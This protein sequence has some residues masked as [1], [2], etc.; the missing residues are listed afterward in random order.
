MHS[1]RYT[2]TFA[3]VICVSCGVLLA[4]VAE[5][6]RPAIEKNEKFDI[7]R[8][9]LKATGILED[10]PQATPETMTQLYEK[11]IREIVINLD[12]NQVPG[13]TPSETDFKK[14]K[15][16][17]PVY[18]R[19]DGDTV[20]AYCF[21]VSGKGLW[22]QIEGY[23]ALG[24]DADHIKGITFYKHGE[25]PGLGGEISTEEYTDQFKGK[26]I[27]DDSGNM[28]S[29]TIA[30]GKIPESMPE[31]HKKHMVDGIS[32]ATLTGKGINVF[33]AEDLKKYEPYLRQIRKQG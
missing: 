21:P 14:E 5:T 4:V 8:N 32:G 9:I 31:D 1:N 24:N 22:S 2:I 18:L 12:G 7:R 16:L 26:T 29:I 30:K 25:T 17:L 28:V 3:L 27:F 20:K 13:K 33:L 19:M 15:E 10:H 6:L 11:H 23:L